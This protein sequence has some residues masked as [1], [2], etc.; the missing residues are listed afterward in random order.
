MGSESIAHEAE[1]FASFN[2]YFIFKD[3][4]KSIEK[5]IFLIF[6]RGVNIVFCNYQAEV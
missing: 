5:I 6:R 3:R 1:G 4:Q 2:L